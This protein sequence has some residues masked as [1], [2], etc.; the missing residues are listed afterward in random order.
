VTLYFW[1][2]SIGQMPKLLKKYS[3]K[4][5]SL[6]LLKR[7]NYLKI[8]M[9]SLSVFFVFTKFSGKGYCDFEI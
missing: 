1:V 9:V 7:C 3:H 4:K 6:L 2:L 8:C 5:N